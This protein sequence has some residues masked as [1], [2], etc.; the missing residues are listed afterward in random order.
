MDAA[1]PEQRESERH[2]VVAD[3][4]LISLGQPT[5]L[6]AV[7]RD[8]SDTGCQLHGPSVEQIDDVFILMTRE[9]NQPVEFDC[10]VVWR[11]DQ[12]IGVRFVTGAGT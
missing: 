5:G 2:S 3:A 12:V 1:A 10:Q 7:V 6:S 8:I 4:R 9:D 11:G